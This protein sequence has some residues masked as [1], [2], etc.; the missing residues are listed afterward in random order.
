MYMYFLIFQQLSLQ[1]SLM[2]K[3]FI[4]QSFELELLI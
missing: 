4:F 1:I 3:N 2:S